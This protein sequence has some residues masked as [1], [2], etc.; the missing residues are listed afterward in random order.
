MRPNLR[1]LDQLT[2]LRFLAA[3]WVFAFHAWPTLSENALY[4]MW[5]R[6]GHL[7]VSFF[8]VLSGFVLTL[9]QSHK[10]NSRQDTHNFWFARAVRILPAYWVAVLLTLL[11]HA[12]SGQTLASPVALGVNLLALQAFFFPFD[13]V[14]LTVFPLGWSITVELF[15][16]ALFPWLIHRFAHRRLSPVLIAV[17]L[18]TVLITSLP[19]SGTFWHEMFHHFPWV[20]INQLLWGIAAARLYLHTTW[21]TQSPWIWYVLGGLGLL[22]VLKYAPAYPG[23]WSWLPYKINLDTGLI[24]PFFA[25]ILLGI[26]RDTGRVSTA[27]RHP[28]C[29]YLGEI[30]YSFYLLQEL[31]MWIFHLGK[32]PTW[33]SYPVYAVVVFGLNLLL[34]MAVYHSVEQPIMRW[35]RVRQKKNT[36]ALPIPSK[37]Q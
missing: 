36:E 33:V 29:V 1:R 11:Y 19:F 3:M 4:Q 13:P 35:W 7:G 31:A 2:F 10:L 28:V 25:A 20:H 37:S 32:G 15:F 27:L 30:S 9:S 23:E 24:A 12:Y 22:L 17:W 16:Y 18:L 14:Y 5:V 26:S 6:K 8:F 34:S 21:G